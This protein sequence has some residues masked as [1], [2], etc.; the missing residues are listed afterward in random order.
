MGT[1]KTDAAEVSVE[2]DWVLVSRSVRPRCTEWSERVYRSF[3]F[4]ATCA[5]CRNLRTR[6]GITLR[7]MLLSITAI[8]GRIRIRWKSHR[9]ISAEAG[10]TRSAPIEVNFGPSIDNLILG[11][12]YCDS[13]FPTW[14]SC[15]QLIFCRVQKIILT[16]PLLV[17]PAPAVV[18]GLLNTITGFHFRWSMVSLVCMYKTIVVVVYGW[19]RG[20]L[21]W[22]RCSHVA[23]LTGA[24]DQRTASRR[25]SMPCPMSGKGFVMTGELPSPIMY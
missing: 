24:P 22:T 7:E 13:G 8:V 16:A 17:V 12:Y 10:E 21:H 1:A 9:S 11:Y 18:F 4:S 19:G 25:V 2:Q 3:S 15:V 5:A 14:R 6:L 20:R 23:R